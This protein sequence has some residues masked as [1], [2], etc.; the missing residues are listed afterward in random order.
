MKARRSARPANPATSWAEKTARSQRRIDH[1]SSGLA[2]CLSSLFSEARFRQRLESCGRGWLDVRMGN[3]IAG[4]PTFVSDR[5]PVAGHRQLMLDLLCERLRPSAC[6][7]DRFP[8]AAPS[9]IY[10]I[11]AV[12]INAKLEDAI[13]IGP[14]LVNVRQAAVMSDPAAKETRAMAQT[15]HPLELLT[16]PHFSSNLGPHSGCLI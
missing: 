11:Y 6:E 12:N 13:A 14:H 1:A 5:A 15:T 16:K 10:L 4:K 3:S 8:I 7:S 2:Q 9:E